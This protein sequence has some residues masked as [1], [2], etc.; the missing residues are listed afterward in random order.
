MSADSVNSDPQSIGSRLRQARV[1]AGLTQD[2]AVA[3]LAQGGVPLTKGGL[4]KYE[5]GGSTP[6]P[7]VLRALAAIYGVDASFFLE[8]P[9]VEIEWLAFRKAAKLGKTAQERVKAIAESQVEAFVTLRNALEP[10]RRAETPTLITVQAVE[11]IED[12]ALSLR[13]HWD[14]GLQPIESVTGVIEDSGGIV[15][16]L[17][18][19]QDLFDGLSGWA[20]ESTPIV[21]V[22]RAVTDDRRRFSLAH[23]LGH[24]VMKI[25]VKLDEKT[26]ER[27][28]HRFAAAFL[29][30]A[31][32][33]KRELGGRRRHLDF[34]ELMLLKQKHGLSMSAWIFR[35][36]DLGIIEE[37]HARTL[38]AEMGQRGWRRHEP[39]D[40]EGQEQPTKFKQL[41]VRALAEGILSRTQAER[42]CPGVTR[43]AED[44]V[45]SP[46]SAMDPRSLHRMPRDQ[47]ERLMEQAA[48]LVENDYRKHGSLDGFDALAEEDHSDGSL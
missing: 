6:K 17:D 7:T 28:A 12:A 20:D 42:L 39:V 9:G 45:A 16:E 43:N 29:V 25:E 3:R 8:D 14:L 23:E 11:G 15:V 22:S 24:L 26:E 5:R 2:E 33:A 35:A 13:R 19:D 32:V 4:S 38:F 34:R 37:S 36:S 1:A 46:A 18:D 31:E 40:F 47:R 10:W 41:T 44:K 27:W 30:P 48:A 21:A